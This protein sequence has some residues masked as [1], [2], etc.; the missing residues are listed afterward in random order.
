M[1]GPLPGRYEAF[2][3]PLMRACWLGKEGVDTVLWSGAHA[4]GVVPTV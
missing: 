4:A 2:T 3:R 1:K